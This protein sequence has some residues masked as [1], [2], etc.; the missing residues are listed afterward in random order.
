MRITDRNTRIAI[1]LQ[2][3]GIALHYPHTTE[4]KANVGRALMGSIDVPLG[5]DAQMRAICKCG[6]E[7]TMLDCDMQAYNSGGQSWS[8]LAGR[9]GTHWYCPKCRAIV[10]KYYHTIS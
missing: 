9:E 8:R 7:G 3:V 1:M 2:S 10:W 5:K 6:W 4:S